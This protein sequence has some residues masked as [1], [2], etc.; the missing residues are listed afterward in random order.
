MGEI[1]ENKE[2]RSLPFW[3]WNDKLKIDKLLKQIQWMYDKGMG[4]FFMH[5]RSGLQTEYLSD[6]WMKCVEKCAD[7]AKR[8]GMK[9]WL[10]DENGWPSGFVGGKLL[11]EEQNRDKYILSSRGAFD[12]NAT[13]SYLLTEDKLLR[14]YQG[15]KDGEYLN[16]YIHTAV[17]TVDILNPEVVKKFLQLTHEKYKEYFGEQFSEFIEGF[18][19]DEPQYHRWNTPYTDMLEQYYQKEYGIDILDE[20][21]LLFVEKAGYRAFRY[22]YWSALQQLMLDSFAKGVYTWCEENGVKLTGHYIEESSIGAQL[23]CC[24][25]VMP[26]YEYMHIPGID[27]LGKYVPS[28]FVAKQVGSV[29]A[30]FGKNRVMTESYAMCGWDISP[31]E[32]KYITA[33]QFVNGVNM[34]CQHLLP[35]SERG[36]RK[37]DYPAHYSDVNPWVAEAYESFNEYFAKLGTL[38]GEGKQFTNVAVLHPLRSGYFDYKRDLEDEGFGI[39]EWEMQVRNACD[40]LAFR[41][42]DYHFLDETLLRKYGSLQDG[43]I[44]CGQCQYEFLILPYLKTMDRSTEKLLRQYVQQGGKVLIL[45]EEL[46][47]L[48]GET[49]DYPYLTSNVSL[50]MIQQGQKYRVIHQDARVYSTYR[51]FEGKEYLY[52]VN[53]STKEKQ[54]QE[55]VF[56]E[57]IQS[58]I[59]VDLLTGGEKKIPL[60]LT[61]EPGEDLLLIPCEE[62]VEPCVAKERVLFHM[63]DA[64]VSIKENYLPVDEISY[65][66]DGIHFSKPWP[67]AALF[68]KLLSERYK[69]EIYFRYEFEVRTIPKR[70][71]IRME[72]SNVKEVYLNGCVMR[73]PIPESES[74]IERYDIAP[75]VKQG[76]NEFVMRVEWYEKDEVYYALFGENVTESLKN[77]IVYDTEL[78][79]IEL[80][81]EFAVFPAEGYRQDEHPEYIQ[82]ERFYIDEMPDVVTEPST[83]GMPFFAGEM[84]IKQTVFWE[85]ENILLDVQGNY[86]IADI[87]V[88]GTYMGRLLFEHVVDVSPVARQGWNE[89]EIRFVISNRNRMGPHHSAMKKDSPVTPYLFELFGE[90][91]EDKCEYYHSYYDIK[92][93]HKT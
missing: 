76:K 29:A 37:Y 55:F 1:T 58:F 22:R 27:K 16:L 54:T 59:K 46:N 75:H 67:C 62:P 7:E 81:G 86:Q 61:L 17:S 10:Y 70:I 20:L 5:A 11:E 89:V 44:Q 25:G 38:L 30:Q 45:G 36:N 31:S 52:V 26:F 28:I 60:T 79:P 49:F 4:G 18:F 3:S 34:I 35:Y 80:V 82:G 42:V 85:K 92:K 51:S 91:K 66:K 57:E 69:G 90:W 6:E 12:E 9:A 13:V 65:S 78:Q 64:T 19:T 15:T 56:G 88:N 73:E 84:T 47:Y 72:K 21:G 63:Q 43:V 74:Y 8:L 68:Q 71:C 48:E 50:E 53:E 23:M 39:A 33:V 93:F 83:D 41:G 24:G 2:Y 77:C 32:L 87:R 40:M 14:V